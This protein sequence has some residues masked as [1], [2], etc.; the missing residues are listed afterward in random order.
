MALDVKMFGN[1]SYVGRSGNV[2]RPDAVEIVVVVAGIVEAGRCDDG[3]V[4]R[5]REAA[6]FD[7][8]IDI[9]R[10]FDVSWRL[11]WHSRLF[12]LFCCCKGDQ[13]SG[14]LKINFYL[15]LKF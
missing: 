1:D 9:F 5:D 8:C 13:R 12:C 4:G 3:V 7:D 11:S 2:D 10:L 15:L 14:E 6:V